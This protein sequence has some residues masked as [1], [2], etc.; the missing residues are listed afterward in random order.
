MWST[1]VLVANGDVSF[2][3]APTLLDALSAAENLSDR[4][5]GLIYRQAVVRDRTRQL[6]AIGIEY[7]DT[8]MPTD[9]G[10]D[11]FDNR[12]NP[13]YTR[14][15]GES[16]SAAA[17]NL[18]IDQFDVGN[19]YRIATSGQTYCSF[20]VED[21]SYAMGA[22]LTPNANDMGNYLDRESTA[23]EASGSDSGWIEVTS[24]QAQAYANQGYLTVA[25]RND[26]IGH[27]AIVR[28][29]QEDNPNNDARGGPYIANAGRSN[30]EYMRVSQGWQNIDGVKDDEGK[31]II[32]PVSYYVHR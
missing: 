16:R 8:R 21:V 25:S 10:R 24:S 22:R 19:R 26:T 15:D 7:R 9:N 18:I 12:W 17:Y 31:Y 11:Q 28:P 5:F 32:Q 30:F 23:N 1:A 6:A 2:P 29:F 3:N 27:V 13:M 4:A 20:F 14:I